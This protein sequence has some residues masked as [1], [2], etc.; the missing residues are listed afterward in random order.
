MIS[1]RSE[2]RLAP[3]NPTRVP[4]N[5]AVIALLPV[6]PAAIAALAPVRPPRLGRLAAVPAVPPVTVE[7]FCPAFTPAGGVE[8]LPDKFE[9]R[10]KPD[11]LAGLEPPGWPRPTKSQESFN[12]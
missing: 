4:L 7:K 1:A 2:S 12:P 3:E 5:A 6:R 9:P 10:F 8:K 11:W